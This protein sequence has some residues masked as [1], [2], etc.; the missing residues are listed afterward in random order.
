MRYPLVTRTFV[1]LGASLGSLIIPVAGLDH[2]LWMV[3]DGVL[4][5]ILIICVY[6]P[7]LKR[8]WREVANDDPR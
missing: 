3:L 2:G 6:G 5:V 4:V 1:G 7:T 8:A